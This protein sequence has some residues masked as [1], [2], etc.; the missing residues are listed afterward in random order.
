MVLTN[1]ALLQTLPVVA[2]VWRAVR[3]AAVVWRTVT[4]GTEKAM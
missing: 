4:G 3:W 1:Q 2:V